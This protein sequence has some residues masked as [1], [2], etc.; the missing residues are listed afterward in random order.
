MDGETR[1]LVYLLMLYKSRPRH[2]SRHRDVLV[3]TWLEA[4][5]SGNYSSVFRC[6]LHDEKPG[7]SLAATTAKCDF[8]YVE[9]RLI[10]YV[11]KCCDFVDLC[12]VWFACFENRA[13]FSFLLN[14]VSC[15]LS[16]PD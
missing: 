10:F 9:Q 3:R 7:A 6:F 4:C 15:V 2:T 11:S 5:G 16:S 13:G 12:V 14:S 1:G 8:K